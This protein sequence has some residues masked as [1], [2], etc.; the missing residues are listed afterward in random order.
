MMHSRT[1]GFLLNSLSDFEAINMRV[2]RI[3]ALQQAY[4]EAAPKDVARWSRVGSETQGTLVLFADNSAVAARLRQSTPRLLAIIRKRCPEVTSIRIEAQVVRNSKVKNR[5]KGRI[6]TTGLGNLQ[7]LAGSLSDGPLR[8]AISNL[9]A[10]QTSASNGENQALQHQE[11]HHDE[12]HKE[13]VLEHLPTETQPTSIMREQSHSDT[14][15]DDN[16][17]QETQYP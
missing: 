10:R 17:G 9:I 4:L 2:R 13:R 1:I 7:G 14:G 6:G 15:A 5:Q 8:A 11:G 16:Q 12:G 3:A